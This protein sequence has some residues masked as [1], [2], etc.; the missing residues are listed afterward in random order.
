VVRRCG[1]VDDVNRQGGLVDKLDAARFLVQPSEYNGARRV[2][3]NRLLHTI[4][5]APP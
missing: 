2:R 4:Q 1:D 3:R 5:R